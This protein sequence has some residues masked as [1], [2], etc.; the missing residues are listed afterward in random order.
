MGTHHG[1]GVAGFPLAADGEGDDGAGVAGEVVFAAG[2]EGGGPGVSVSG[3]EDACSHAW[4]MLL[5]SA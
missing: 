3:S 5:L 2:L 1:D 4:V